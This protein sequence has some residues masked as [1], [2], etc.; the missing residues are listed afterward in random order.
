M[1]AVVVV[2]A[3]IAN[4]HVGVGNGAHFVRFILPTL[5]CAAVAAVALA[6]TV[7]S[8]YCCQ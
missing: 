2:V 4:W 8:C 3:A 5:A 1:M 6:V 7:A